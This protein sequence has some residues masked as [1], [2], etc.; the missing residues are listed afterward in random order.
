MPINDGEIEG[1]DRLICS[2]AH[3]G[4]YIRIVSVGK[5][6]LVALSTGSHIR[7][8]SVGTE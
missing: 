3:I 4:C 7:I 6:R 1:G 5:D 2:S 8:V